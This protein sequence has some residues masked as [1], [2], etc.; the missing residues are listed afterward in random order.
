M[1]KTIFSQIEEGIKGGKTAF[2]LEFNTN[3]RQLLLEK[4]IYP[5]SLHLALA[6]YFGQKGYHCG[7]FSPGLAEVQE[8]NPPDSNATGNNPFRMQGTNK[9]LNLYTP[10]LRR[11]DTKVVLIV[12]YADLLAPVAEGSIFLQPEQQIVLETLHRWGAD[13]AIRQA[14]NIVILISYEGGVN[15]LLTRSGVYQTIQIPLPDEAT[16]HEFIHLLLNLTDG[17]NRKYAKLEDGFTAEEMSRVSNGLRLIDIEALFRSRSDSVIK[18]DDIQTIKSNAIREMAGGLVEVVEPI[19][20]FESIAGLESVKE[21]FKFLKWMF[22]NGSPAVPY[23]MIL[24]GVPGSGK[25]KL[26]STL[27]KELNL[28]LLILRNLHGPFVGQSEANLERVLRIV[29]SMSPCVVLIEEIDQGIGQRGTGLSGDSGTTNRM[30]QRFWEALGS[31]QKNR[32][33]NLWIG[34]SNRPDL[35]DTAMLDR[36]QVII[37]FLH[38]TP[39]EVST[40]L[41]VIAKQIN[42]KLADDIDLISISNL[43]NLYLPTVRGLVEIMTSAAQRADYESGI[44]NSTIE[45]KH[46]MAAARDYKITYDVIQHEYIALKAVE[47]VS[48]SSLLPWMSFNGKRPDAEI[49]SYLQE[50]VDPDGYLDTS[51]LSARIRELEQ[52]LFSQKMM[53]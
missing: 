22:Q 16:R 44:V 8:L 13:D 24:A 38:P 26:C 47:M 35:L 32:G 34:T 37:P 4:G 51:K 50:I 17:V 9:S 23:A 33:K 52:V 40:L 1:R 25:S 28:P 21:Y 46:L 45:N 5:T 41:P 7:L 19:E 12:Q 29:E 36:F 30:S 15:S 42:R 53:H 48:F 18:R 10:I 14:Q 11:K 3:D 43:P 49:P 2:I 20:G 6:T 39:R 27:A 31:S